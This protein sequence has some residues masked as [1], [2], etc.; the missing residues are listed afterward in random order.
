MHIGSMF[1]KFRKSKNISLEKLSDGIV[2]P[3]FLAKFERGENDIS[4]S[5]FIKLLDRMNVT[6]HEFTVYFKGINQNRQSSFIIEYAKAVQEKNIH[7]LN[8][9][10]KQETNFYK[11]NQNIRHLHNQIL[12]SQM[13][14]DINS[15]K[16][17]DKMTSIITNYLLNINDWGYYETTL[18]SNSLFFLPDETLNY[19]AIQI[20][21]NKSQF[22]TTYLDKSESAIMLTNIASLLIERD[23]IGSLDKIFQI[24]DD[25]VYESIYYFPITKMN[26]I[27]GLYYLKLN[28]TEAG[29]K[30]A[31]DAIFIMT[32]MK[33]FSSAKNFQEYLDDFISNYS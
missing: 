26:F 12:A 1:R 22:R 30:L 21:T 6:L 19:T 20:V 2:S 3:S 14:H 4:V 10:I 29:L 16:F 9:L 25:L 27:K 5:S 13:I 32:Y 28:D 8:Y 17:D 18:L 33:N 11:H 15:E 31:N 23:Y 24:F 7:L